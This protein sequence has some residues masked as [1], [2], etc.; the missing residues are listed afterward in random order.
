MCLSI[1]VLI[2]LSWAVPQL[3]CTGLGLCL[4]LYRPRAVPRPVQALGCASGC[5]SGCTGLGLYRP[6]AVPRALNSLACAGLSLMCS[7]NC[8]LA[9][10]LTD[11]G[12]HRISS[13]VVLYNRRIHS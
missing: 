3:G 10:A 5:A 6:R 4:G 8:P 12:P 2:R 9:F 7:C 13:A 11:T 1:D